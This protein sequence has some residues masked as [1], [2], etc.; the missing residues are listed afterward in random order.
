MLKWLNGTDNVKG[1]PNENYAREMMELFTL[2]ADR[3]AYSERDVR[4]QARSLTGWQN[5]WKSGKGAYNFRFVARDH[6]SGMKTVFH[7]SGNFDWQDA[8][9]L[10]V[11]HP[12]HPSFF[13][14]KLWSYFV[15]VARA[16]RR[17][18]GSR[19]SIGRATRSHRSSARSSSIRL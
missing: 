17:S 4:E 12:A 3:G 14:N 13:V 5:S 9:R 1:A 10:C 16:A 15:P 19:R 8:C 6:D 18:R 7:R 11:S 2:G